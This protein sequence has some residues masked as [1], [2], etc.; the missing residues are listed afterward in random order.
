MG[1]NQVLAAIL[2]VALYSA[3]PRANS[4]RVP[5][6]QWRDVLHDYNKF[7]KELERTDGSIDRRG[8]N[9]D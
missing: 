7:L 5:A 2:T 3:K 6:K 4:K 1:D 9:P 8:I